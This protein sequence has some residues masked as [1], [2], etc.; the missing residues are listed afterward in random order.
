MKSPLTA[1]T[2]IIFSNFYGFLANKRGG[3]V[4]AVTGRKIENLSYRQDGLMSS[5]EDQ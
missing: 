2:S 1:L 3:L 4:Q 5:K